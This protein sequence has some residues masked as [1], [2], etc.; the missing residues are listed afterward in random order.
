[1][2]TKRQRRRREKGRRHEYEYV[3]VDESGDEVAVEEPEEKAKPKA[4][5][6]ET[7]KQP[8][9]KEEPR[10]GRVVEPPTWNRVARRALIFAPFIVLFLYVVKPKDS[11]VGAALW[12]AAVMIALLIPFMYLVD[13][14]AYK[15]YRKR[16]DKKSASKPKGK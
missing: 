2:A 11:S 7:R 14:M 10:A 4:E 9:K 5:K 1:M 3:Y 8:A 12:P 13:S 15:A 6:A 16:A